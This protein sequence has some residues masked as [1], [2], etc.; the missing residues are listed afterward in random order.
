MIEKHGRKFASRAEL[1]RFEGMGE[2]P[3][4]RETAYRRIDCTACKVARSALVRESE[5]WRLY[6][7]ECGAWISIPSEFVVT[8][9]ATL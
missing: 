3:R 1:R 8:W 9:E 7:C 6:H 5:G 2:Q 4:T